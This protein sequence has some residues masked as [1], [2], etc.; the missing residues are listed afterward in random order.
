MAL[1]AE[2]FV[3]FT[4]FENVE[5]VVKSN[6]GNTT[7]FS[8]PKDLLEHRSS[9]FRK[10]LSGGGNGSRD[11]DGLNS[12]ERSLGRSVQSVCILATRRQDPANSHEG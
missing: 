4:L 7:S 5:I 1:S 12:L 3:K 11:D 9:W 6:D 2:R 8:L 10:A